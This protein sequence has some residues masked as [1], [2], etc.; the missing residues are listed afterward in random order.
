MMDSYPDAPGHRG[1]DTSVDA[2][3]IAATKAPRLRRLVLG[4]LCEHP[5]NLTVDQVCAIAKLPRYS[6]QPRFSEL[7]KLG[8][9][10]DT[11][12]RR[13]NV[14]GARAK[15]WRAVW[16]DEQEMAA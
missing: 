9:I 1:N 8:L 6:L 14:S 11:G 15:V 13:E 16:L 2:A 12:E 10:R 7:L 3:A 5:K 4:I